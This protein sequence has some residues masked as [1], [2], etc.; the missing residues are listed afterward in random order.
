MVKTQE[1]RIGNWVYVLKADSD[2]V[3]IGDDYNIY[4]DRDYSPIPLTEDWILKFGF[5]LYEYHLNDKMSDNPDFIYLSY[6]MELDGKR[7][8]YTI[9]NTEFDDWQFCVKVEWAEEMLIASCQYIHQLQNL[10]FALTKTELT[11]KEI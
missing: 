1:L 11:L 10:Y 8:Y 5:E 4:L 2:P 3:R 7:Y 6:K 9:T